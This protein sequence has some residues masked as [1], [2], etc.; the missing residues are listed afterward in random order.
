MMKNDYIAPAV[1]VIKLQPIRLL[2]GSNIDSVNNDVNVPYLGGSTT[3]AFSRRGR[4]WDED[5]D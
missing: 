1:T 4:Q 3:G 2:E 5:D